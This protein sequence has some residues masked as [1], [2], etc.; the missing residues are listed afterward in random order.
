MNI[1]HTRGTG[2][3]R[4]RVSIEHVFFIKLNF[5]RTKQPQQFRLEILLS[6]MSSLARYIPLHTGSC[7]LLTEN[8]E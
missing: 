2:V 1:G 6:M 5:M 3:F 7:D 4:V 8:T